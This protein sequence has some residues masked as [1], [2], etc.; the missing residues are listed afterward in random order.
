MHRLILLSLLIASSCITLHAQN[1]RLKSAEV[2]FEIKNAGFTVKGKFDSLPS[3][4]LTM[5]GGS[6]AKMALSGTVSAASIN[7]GIGIRDKHLRK[8]DYFDTEKYPVISLQST[9][10]QNNGKELLGNFN[11]QIKQITKAV[12]MVITMAENGN[13]VEMNGSFT[14]NRKDFGVGGNSMTLADN[15]DVFV[16]A[17][18]EK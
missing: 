9:G 5:P 17:V 10:I 6:P 2:R 12:K 4:K 3:I 13:V 18:F 16:H 8:P 1:Y 15:V 14:I 11:L 7:T